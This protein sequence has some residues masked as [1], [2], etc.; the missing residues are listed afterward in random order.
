M[1]GIAIRGPDG[2]KE[3]NFIQMIILRADVPELKAYLNGTGRKWLSPGIQN[4]IFSLIARKILN[5]ILEKIISSYYFSIMLDETP[6]SGR[7]E[8]ISV[9]ASVDSET[10][11]ISEYFLRFY[12]TEVTTA[13]ILLKIVQDIFARFNLSMKHLRGQCFDDTSNMNRPQK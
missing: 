11:E 3:S 10:F 4:K 7:L 1:R 12:N 2:D 6:D 9:L 13:N 5:G 8:Q